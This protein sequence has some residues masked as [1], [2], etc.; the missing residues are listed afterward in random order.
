MSTYFHITMIWLRPSLWVAASLKPPKSVP[1]ICEVSQPGSLRSDQ[2]L[3]V[4]CS[5]AHEALLNFIR[6]DLV[7][8]K[9][10]ISAQLILF[11]S[12]YHTDVC[13]GVNFHSQFGFNR[14]S[15]HFLPLL[16]CRGH[17]ACWSLPQHHWL[18]GKFSLD[19]NSSQGWSVETYNRH[20]ENMQHATCNMHSTQKCLVMG[21]KSCCLN[22]LAWDNS[23]IH[24]V[25]TTWFV[26][27]HSSRLDWWVYGQEFN[28]VIRLPEAPESK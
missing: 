7:K 11:I 15:H 20:R 27:E 5:I 28:T 24:C 4:G 23:T 26:A 14:L 2:P 10:T 9:T 25:K 8:N 1:D 3:V 22:L 21:I 16:L 13:S 17:M 18:K 19:D 6:Y 12:F